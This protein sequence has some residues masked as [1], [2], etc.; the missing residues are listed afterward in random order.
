ML[1]RER[2][3]VI[4]RHRSV[5]RPA[6]AQITGIEDQGQ[7]CPEREKL[8]KDCTRL[9]SVQS[10]N[11][12]AMASQSVDRDSVR[13]PVTKLRGRRNSSKL[14]KIRDQYL[15]LMVNLYSYVYQTIVFE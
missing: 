9:L 4:T 14:K 12:R 13:D 5:T 6:I 2:S 8:E 3:R 7:M 10:K 15:T 11:G 1:R